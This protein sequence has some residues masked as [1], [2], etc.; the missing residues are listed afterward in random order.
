MLKFNVSFMDLKKAVDFINFCVG[1]ENNDQPVITILLAPDIE[2][3]QLT[4]F[5]SG[6]A[7]M[8]MTRI[9]AIF[10]DQNEDGIQCLSVL[11]SKIRAVLLHREPEYLVVEVDN[12]VVGF[13]YGGAV[14]YLD[15]YVGNM[16]DEEIKMHRKF[17][18][19]SCTLA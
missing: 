16:P 8:G 14:I 6:K 15:N 17:H 3:S 2:S 11:L 19:Y 1:P 7:L 9:P 13:E 18:S 4:L 5:V 12:K 10:M